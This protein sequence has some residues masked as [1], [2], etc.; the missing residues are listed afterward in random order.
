MLEDICLFTIQLGHTDV[1]LVQFFAW[2]LSFVV[3]SRPFSFDYRI[4]SPFYQTLVLAWRKLGGAFV[5]SKSSLVY[6]SS[7]PLV[8]SPVVS[9]SAKSCYLYLLSDSMV[10][11]H[12]ML[13]FQLIYPNLDWPATWRALS[14]FH[15]DRRVF[16]INWKIA[17]GVLYTARRLSRLVNLFPS[18]ASM[19]PGSS[20][21]S[22]C[23]FIVHLPR[24]LSAGCIPYCF[25]SLLSCLHLASRTLWL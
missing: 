22:S 14:F 10:Q 6:G 18:R 16:D 25:V 7:C 15:L 8:C 11:P 9:M 4:L 17:H 21:S 2:Y 19:G 23:S 13:K 1:P 3:F 12:C 5:T 24:V 20:H